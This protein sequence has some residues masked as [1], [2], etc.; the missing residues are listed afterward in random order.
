MKKVFVAVLSMFLAYSAMAD[1][2]IVMVRHAEKPSEGLGQLTCQGFNRALKLTAVLTQKFGNPQAIYAPNPGVLKNDKGT[3]YYYVR[4][5]AT[6]EPTAIRLGMPVNLKYAFAE[7]KKMTEE[8]LQPQYKD[9]TIYV[10]WE[11]HLAA[12]IAEDILIQKNG[13]SKHLKWDDEDFDSIY[14]ITIK[15]ESGE[16]K[17]EIQSQGLNEQSKE[18]N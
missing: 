5:L 4:P 11:H 9:S 6:I 10:A 12:Q 17:L 15:S 3:D 1:E 14:V 7:H 13:T 8:L 18:C 2:T 16:A